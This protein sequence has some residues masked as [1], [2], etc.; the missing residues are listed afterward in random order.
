[1]LGFLELGL[2]F[3]FLSNADLVEHWGIL[4]REIFIGI[5]ILVGIG[6]MLYLFG[7]IRFPHDGPKKKLTKTRFGFG[8]LTFLFVLYLIPGLTNSAFANLKLL[9]GFPPPLFY[10]VYEKDTQGPLGLKAYKSWEKGLE[11]AKQENK[12]IMLDFTGWA[13]VNC[14]KMEEQVWSDPAV[15]EV[16]KNNYILISLYVDDREELTEQDQ[17]NYVRAN[18]SIKKIRTIGDKWATF[19]TVNFQNNSQPFYVLLD[20]DLNLLNSPIGYTPDEK[21]Y[22]AWLN[23]GIQK[24]EID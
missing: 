10:S 16:L 20:R 12:P 21:E 7:L 4:K 2:A 14:R 17:F 8:A 11:A 3:K 15:Y 1:V 19:Q 13:C 18:G 5:W 6:L 22:L 9:S 24:V 23:Q